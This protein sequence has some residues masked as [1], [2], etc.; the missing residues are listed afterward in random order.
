MHTHMDSLTIYGLYTTFVICQHQI[1]T[2]FSLHHI[3]GGFNDSHTCSVTLFPV[4]ISIAIPAPPVIV[5]I[6]L[7][8]R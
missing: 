8:G 3:L 7:P 5:P 2:L 1:P 4:G 6:V